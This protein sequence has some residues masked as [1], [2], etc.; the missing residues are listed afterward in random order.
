MQDG[1][2]LG[3]YRLLELTSHGAGGDMWRALDTVTQREVALRIPC[4]QDTAGA[5]AKRDASYPAYGPQSGVVVEYVV[6]YPLARPSEHGA[7]RSTPDPPVLKRSRKGRWIALLSAAI[8]VV[9]AA[10][11]AT[12]LVPR[13]LERGASPPASSTAAP[14]STPAN[15]GP[16]TGNFRVSM[17]PRLTGSGAPSTADGSEAYSETWQL[18]SVCIPASCVATASTGGWYPVGD[19]V[20]DRVGQRWLAVSTSRKQCGDRDDESFNAILLEPQ[21]D[22]TLSGESTQATTGGC[23]SRRTVTFTRT[24]D[25]DIAQLP[26][27]AGLAPRKVS[28]A[29]AMRGRYDAEIT[30]ANR[31]KPRVQHY[32]V[33]TDC[34]RAGDRCMSFF[35]APDGS[36]ESYVF[37]NGAW[38]LNEEY[39]MTCSTGGSYRGAFSATVALPQPLQDPIP[40]LI[41]HGYDDVTQAVGSACQSQA[42]DETFTRTGD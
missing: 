30:Y 16:L 6:D 25:T 3:R 29:E 36:E 40:S 14:A 28:P 27:P 19:L 38:T 10:V 12:I 4:A 39:G 31:Y 17:G 13:D 18:R 2:P 21:P 26:D 1:T 24:G 33:R 35:L 42:Y 34:L 5:A 20:F 37:A 8:V 11:A 15:T 32:G 23:F 9:A 7:D 22:G 41:G